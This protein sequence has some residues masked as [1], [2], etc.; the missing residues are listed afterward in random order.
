MARILSDQ[1]GLTLVEIMV[2]ALISAFLTGA[3]LTMFLVGRQT[4]ASSNAYVSVQQQARQVIGVLTQELRAAGNVNSDTTD[5]GEDFTDAT[6]INAQLNL[7]YDDDD[8]G[9]VCWGNDDGEDGWVHYVLN[10]TDAS[11]TQLAR[12]LSNAA[13]T[14]I[15][16]FSDCRVV[17]NH[18][19][20]FTANYSNADGLLT[21]ALEIQETSTQLVS[22]GMGTTPDPLYAQIRLRN[23]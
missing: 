12:C 9:G 19:G 17:A 4:W 2:A 15:A 10:T 20:S 13:D 18:V 14:T 21:L 6:R 1:R 8:C 3:V 5:P 23:N 16:D 11:N 7:E 22:G